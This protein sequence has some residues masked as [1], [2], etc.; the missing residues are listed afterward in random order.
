MNRLIVAGSRTLLDKEWIYRELDRVTANGDFPVVVQGTATGPDKIGADWG[1]A[2]GKVVYDYPANW[3]KYGK[4]AGYKRNQA[5]AEFGTHL[6]AFYD[7]S[8]KGTRHMIDIARQQGLV[9]RVIRS[10]DV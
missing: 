7:G 6:V 10:D 4:S 3:T 9:V 5:M 8:S 1:R 2:R